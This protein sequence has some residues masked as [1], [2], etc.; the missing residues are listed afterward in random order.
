MGDIRAECLSRAIA[1]RREEWGGCGGQLTEGLKSLIVSR[2]CLTWLK[3]I[4]A[5]LPLS[6]CSNSWRQS[7]DEAIAAGDV[8]VVISFS[9]VALL[10]RQT[11]AV[12]V[13]LLSRLARCSTV[14]LFLD[15]S[16]SSGGPPS[17]L[18]GGPLLQGAPLLQGHAGQL[19]KYLLQQMPFAIELSIDL[20]AWET[21]SGALA[22]EVLRLICRST[23][24]LT[25]LQL[26][27]ALLHQRMHA[28]LA[29][30]CSLYPVPRRRHLSPSIEAQCG[31]SKPPS[32]TTSCS[33]DSSNVPS[34]NSPPACL[35]LSIHT[36]PQLHAGQD[37]GNDPPHGDDP[38]PPT[39]HTPNIDISSPSSQ[40][41]PPTSDPLS[42]SPTP[43]SPPPSEVSETTE[44][45]D[46]TEPTTATAAAT[47]AATAAAT[48]AIAAAEA[49]AAAT[50]AEAGGAEEVLPSC[51][52][53][54]GKEEMEDW[55]ESSPED[56]PPQV[57]P[58]EYM[59]ERRQG[60]YLPNL[61]RLSLEGL[62]L[63][64]YL[65][66]PHLEETAITLTSE[67]LSLESLTTMYYD[68]ASLPPSLR[69]G[70]PLQ[71]PSYRL[72]G[73]PT[74]FIHPCLPLRFLKTYGKHLHTLKVVGLMGPLA[75]SELAHWA[76]RALETLRRQQQQQQQQEQHQGQEQEQEQQQEQQTGLEVGSGI[77]GDTDDSMCGARG[78]SRDKSCCECCLL[79]QETAANKGWLCCCSLGELQELLVEETSFL[80]FV[81]PPKLLQLE[82]TVCC[83]SDWMLLLEFLRLY[84]GLLQQLTVWGDEVCPPSLGPLSPSFSSSSNISSS[85]ISRV[86]GRC[87]SSMS[88]PEETQQLISFLKAKSAAERGGNTGKCLSTAA[89]DSSKRVSAVSPSRPIRLQE[90]KSLQCPSCLLPELCCSIGTSSCNTSIDFLP[91][92]RHLDTWGDARRIVSFLQ[93]K[94]HLETVVVRSITN[95]AEALKQCE[96]DIVSL[97]ASSGSSNSSRSGSSIGLMSSSSSG[98]R[99]PISSS[100]SR[101]PVSSSS[102]GKLSTSSSS[103]K[104]PIS[105]STS[106]LN[107]L[108]QQPFYPCSS[109]TAAAAENNLISYEG[110]GSIL[111]SWSIPPAAAAATAAVPV[112]AAVAA[113]GATAAAPA[114]AA[115]T[116]GVVP[117]EAAAVV[118]AAAAATT[119]LKASTDATAVP[120]VSSYTQSPSGAVQE[121]K[122]PKGGPLQGI[123]DG[124]RRGPPKKSST[125]PLGGSSRTPP[126]RFSGEAPIGYPLEGPQGSEISIVVGPQGSGDSLIVGPQG[127]NDSLLEGPPQPEGS[128]SAAGGSEGLGDELGLGDE[129]GS[130]DGFK[131]LEELD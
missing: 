7:L 10:S 95:A 29:S 56:T 91:S 40:R 42:G 109:P 37:N 1:A 69:A 52:S 82:V 123:E 34:S 111:N 120:P 54:W 59:R 30:G 112:A 51:G 3:T 61:I 128:R 18:Q 57:S 107:R 39:P 96:R 78:D 31:S 99:I 129:E 88:V 53:I 115:T 81:S 93:P 68:L 38:T 125:G 114:V 122:S 105:S 12:Q 33:G 8:P 35:P 130:G 101:L 103:S 48:A 28:L 41:T 127:S 14:S 32:S 65:G 55:L 77:K 79:Q 46:S 121:Q 4:E 47:V 11:H 15:F 113:A 106:C 2:C 100:S 45:A 92:L 87:L 74:S 90:L 49:T 17:L 84:G 9:C 25:T 98:G 118:A 63:L 75:K 83:S 24:T 23:S 19:V 16:L 6:C 58:H 60:F 117:A 13:S 124:P 85:C 108:P 64:Q 104:L 72:G 71:V 67:A 94:R 102:S 97:T 76:S 131:G 119:V 44:A 62:Q 21:P 86:W 116:P 110:P 36:T 5:L 20:Q 89:G 80:V 73:P 50:A 27:G 66:A 26:R 43:P 22:A 126:R 70:P